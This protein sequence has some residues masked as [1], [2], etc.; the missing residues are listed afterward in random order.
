[1]RHHRPHRLR[2]RGL[3]AGT[4]AVAML[5]PVST[6]FAATPPRTD[7]ADESGFHEVG[8]VK[9]PLA[10]P[11]QSGTNITGTAPVGIDGHSLV[12][13]DSDRSA[14]RAFLVD[15]T[16][17]T[18]TKTIDLGFNSRFLPGSEAIDS[19][20]HTLYVGRQ[21]ELDCDQG[22][23]A[24]LD[25][26]GTA[27]SASAAWPSIQV[28]DLTGKKAPAPYTFTAASGTTPGAS[29]V[30]LSSYAY[31]G[32]RYLLA[33][34]YFTELMNVSAGQSATTH[35]TLIVALDAD[36]L[37]TDPA[38]AL[39][40]KAPYDVTN[41]VRP[42]FYGPRGLYLGVGTTG[43]FLYFVC[44]TLAT[45]SPAMTVAGPAGAVRVDLRD[46]D[47]AKQDSSAFTTEYFP[48]AADFTYGTSSGD[49]AHDELYLLTG[50]PRYQ[51]FYV[52]DAV[53]RSFTGSV[54]L[55]FTARGGGN[56]M[57][58]APDP[59]TGRAY[60]VLQDFQVIVTDATTVPVQQGR[61]E[62]IGW[63]SGVS[64]PPVFDPATRRLFL[65]GSDFCTVESTDAGTCSQPDVATANA[66]SLRV[67]QDD[68][69]YSPATADDPDALTH[70]TAEIPGV[71]PVDY[72]AFASSYGARLAA[73]GGVHGSQAAIGYDGAMAGLHTVAPDFPNLPD[74]DRTLYLGQVSDTELST[75][76]A[77]AHAAPF[78]ID[79]GT[80]A[81]SAGV[82]SYLANQLG[83]DGQQQ[84]APAQD[85]VAQGRAEIG[86]AGCSDLGS[87]PASQLNPSG[88]AG[89]FCDNEGLQSAGESAATPAAPVE[90]PGGV[91]F[92]LGSAGSW[93]TL[94]KEKATGSNATATAIARGL[95]IG[96]PGAGSVD[97][98][99]VKT[100]ASS[101]A[102]GR[103]GTT[104][105]SF[106]RSVTNLVISDGS[107]KPQ[108]A[109][110][111]TDPGAT[112]GLA[113]GTPCDP[114]TVT[115][116]LDAQFPGRLKFVMPEPDT[117]PNVAHSPGGSK[118]AVIKPQYVLWN[119]Y[120]TNH[121]DST[122]VPGLQIQVLNDYTQPSR[123]VMS[124]AGVSVESNYRIGQPPPPPPVLPDPSLKLTL[125]DGSTPPLPLAGA[126]FTLQGPAGT[127]PLTCVTAADGIGTC[128][129]TK[130]PPGAYTITETTPPPGYA[131]VEDSTVSLEPNNDYELSYVNLPAIGSVILSL[132]APDEAATPIPGAV[133]ALHKG[134]AL[135]D[136]PL[137]TCTT[138]D[139]GA[140]AFDK[141]PLGE[142]TMEQVSAPEDFL[143]SEAVDFSLTKPLQVA[144]LHFVDGV[145]GKPAI[146]PTVI[147]GTPAVP[148]KV[149]PG[150]PA[151]PP[152]VIPGKPAVPP[153]TMVLPGDGGTG[154]AGLEPASYE[155]SVGEAPIVA[156]QPAG[157]L[158]ALS[159]GSGGLGAVSARLA[160]L[161]I[162][163]PQQA[164][165]LLF[166]WLVLGL[167][168]Y[169]WVRRRQFITATE[170]I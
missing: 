119:D 30:G 82:Q 79:S 123:L 88:T 43:D 138:D 139:K 15:T 50:G 102:H 42:G 63:K 95:H 71:T 135:L 20:T 166:V 103:P 9:I 57:G 49:P 36:K 156:S 122:E 37:L 33:V 64:N 162:H 151:V 118:A 77:R 11:R 146:P 32:H 86:P 144:K 8:A 83:P 91:S 2:R 120:N 108:F 93:T 69:P 111:F 125:V 39:V 25:P 10:Q 78:A 52:F 160:K 17:L 106:T 157:A 35:S 136:P 84:L 154:Q 158:D 65:A 104:S 107:G 148:P 101:A 137:V 62:S 28:V 6:V 16:S 31:G 132:A 29:V 168:V 131:A 56:V 67:Y 59:T 46:P 149:I 99:E 105:S 51:K 22:P 81:D 150:K 114:R 53:H 7:V 128:K 142:Y 38:H 124:L 70:D 159:V 163:S 14:H 121:D 75:A 100:T 140:C 74:S 54:P 4:L 155:S 113:A 23:V 96:V 161:V 130:L 164:V 85:Q 45:S 73:V 152:K 55:H 110:G 18:P 98:G 115:E 1:M 72:S 127:K 44:K 26:T 66:A 117:S 169:L 153:R 24:G 143:V 170:G 97:I 129:L 145:P 58:A 21:C 94:T 90:L 3:L 60:L 40:W 68:V 34:L 112:V 134:K 133:F 48:F 141:V 47:P 76:A 13:L 41:C 61:S 5:L 126:T 12:A 92:S 89:A 116:Q 19:S 165:L 109:C 147:P 167:P 27:M 80:E 87:K